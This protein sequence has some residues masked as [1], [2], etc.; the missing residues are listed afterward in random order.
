MCV[1]CNTKRWREASRAGSGVITLLPVELSSRVATHK[2]N[3]RGAGDVARLI[4]FLASM[5]EPLHK[6]DMDIKKQEDQTFKVTLSYMKSWRS[7][8]PKVLSQKTT[9]T[10]DV[11]QQ[12][13]ICA[14]FQ[15]P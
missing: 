13:R 2:E 14:A 6:L 4:E 9:Q 1:G 3:S 12:R 10:W 15:R 5:H 7:R 8:L 11:V